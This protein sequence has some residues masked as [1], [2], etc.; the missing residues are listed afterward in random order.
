MNV[1]RGLLSLTDGNLSAEVGLDVP[2]PVGKSFV[3]SSVRAS[4]YEWVL[5]YDYSASGWQNPALSYDNDVNTYAHTSGNVYL[6]I[7]ISGMVFC[8]NLRFRGKHTTSGSDVCVDVYYTD[9]DNV[10][11]GEIINDEWI[12]VETNQEVSKVRVKFNDEF[13]PGEVGY[14]SEVQLSDMQ[15]ETLSR[16]L[17][18]VE[19]TTIS[20]DSFTRLKATRDNALSGC[21]AN[22][23]WQVIY[24][25]EFTVQSGYLNC[26]DSL[27]TVSASINPINYNEAFIVQTKSMVLEVC[28]K[29]ILLLVDMVCSLVVFLVKLV[30]LTKLIG[31]LLS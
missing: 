28:L 23:E 31:M 3:I 7:L 13:N 17:C 9:W 20:G 6:E 15:I 18:T 12:E 27:V 22:I 30:M 26:D 4:V 2:V 11:S 19:L 1:Q 25:D 8:D 24:G 16:T 29:P 5:P 10:Y 14:I 21:V